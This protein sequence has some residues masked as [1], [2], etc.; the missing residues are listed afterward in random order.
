MNYKELV[1]LQNLPLDLKIRKT[2]LRIRE[3]Y[4]Y[5]QG[6]VYVSW[7]GGKDSTVLLYLVHRLY[8]DVPAVFV[9]TFM[10]FPSIKQFVKGENVIFLKPQKRFE[11]II[12][13]YGYPVISKK[14][15]R[16]VYELQNPTHSNVATRKLY[17]T[18]Y[19]SKNEY[20]PSFKLP[21]KWHYLIDANFK[22]SNKCCY[23]L[24]HQPIRQFEKE[25][26][27]KPFIGTMAGESQFRERTYLKSGCNAFKSKRKVSTPLGF[28][29]EQDILEFIYRY[30]IPIARCY[31]DV[32]KD[33]YG[34]YYTSLESRT[35][36]MY[37]LYGCHL[38]KGLNRIQRLAIH[39]PKQYSYCINNLGY[40][41]VLDYISIPYHV[42]HD[43]TYYE[44]KGGQLHFN[45][46]KVF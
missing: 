20:L 3:W 31:G 17:F 42:Y 30:K 40:D 11:E 8:K 4:E 34:K 5:H 33:N 13:V 16:M 19:S 28:W 37:C 38:E 35:G 15:S 45:F 10:E 18:G 9:N 43:N 32:C 27:L 24:K 14:V 36:C 26:K 12:K 2:L 7:S 21:E 29:T 6:N 44:A 25:F 22:I 39:H 1:Y 46:N 41:K 23:F